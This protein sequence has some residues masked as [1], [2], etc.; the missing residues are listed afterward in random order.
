MISYGATDPVLNDRTLYPHYLSTGPNEYI[1]HIAIAELVERLGWTWVIILATSNDGGQK[2]SQNLKNEINKHGACVDL[3]GT[4]TGNNDTDKRTLERIQKS[5]AEVVILCGGR[6]YNPYFVFILKEI[7]N[8]KMVVVPVTCVFIPNDF[9][10][11]GC[12]QFQDTNMMS[13]ESLEVK[14]TEHIY[15]PREDELLKDLLANDHL[16]LTHDKEKDD[17]FQRVYK[18]LYR[19]CSNITS[20]MLY[21]YP[22][23]RVSTAVSVLARAQHNLLSSSGKHSNSGLPTIIHRKQILKSQCSTNCPPGYR[24]VPREGAPPCCYDCAP[25]SEGEISNLTDMDNCLKCGDYEWPNPEKTVCIEKQLQFLSFDDCLTLIFIISSVILFIIAAVILRIFISFRD[26]PVVRANNH[27]LSFILLVSIKLSFLS[28][29]L[30][31]GRPVDITCMLRQTSFGIT[32]SIAVSCVLAKTLMVSI[33]FKATKPGSPWR[34]WV[35]VKVAYCIVLFCSIIQILIS[36][37]WL[38]ISPPFLELNFLFE[39]GQIIIQCNEG[40]VIA[41]YIVLS[42]MGLLASVSFIVAFLARSLP[43]SFN[44]AKYITF[45]MLLFC[46]VWIT[47]IPAYLSTKGKY[48]VAVEIFAII[49]S[50][51]GLL[52]CIFLPKCYIILFKPE[53]NSK[54][55]LLG[56]NK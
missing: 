50:S 21:Y 12:L 18:L 26:T 15:A 34:K 5:T 28:V 52:F 30:F 27:T 40:S 10:Y 11:N 14:F 42:Y 37:I 39:P 29:F 3:I 45:S 17:L 1:Q 22:S 35:G 8:N 19:N 32:F 54:R 38:T 33:A 24:K 44:E 43:D 53:M 13:D 2:E 7:I 55:Y 47:M 9:L 4:L 23:H 36:V 16:C 48:M 46:S 41:F 49:S 56:N 51:C 31:L 25:C 20:P 6:S